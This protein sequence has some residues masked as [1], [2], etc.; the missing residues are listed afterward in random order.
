MKLFSEVSE[1]LEEIKSAD[2]LKQAEAGDT[3]TDADHF[4]KH[5]MDVSGNGRTI[6]TLPGD[7]PKHEHKI[8]KWEVQAAEGH[9]HEILA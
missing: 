7:H 4:H 6:Q 8:V 2:P 5:E 9:K 3:S 1:L